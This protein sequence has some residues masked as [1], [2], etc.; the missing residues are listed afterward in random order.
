V[1]GVFSHTGF[2]DAADGASH[3]ATTY[4]AALS[5]I[6]HLKI[7]N[8]SCASEAENLVYTAI[9]KFKEKRDK[10]ETPDSVIFFLGREN[11]P[12]S[13]T[14][15]A[16]YPWKKAQVLTT[17]SAA[18][19]VTSGVLLEKALKAAQELKKENIEVTVVNH[20]FVNIPDIETLTECLKK[21]GGKLITTE[22]HQL[23]CGQGAQI[24]HA[25]TIKGVTIQKYIGLGIKGEFGQSAYTANE[26]Y[27]KHGIDETALINAVRSLL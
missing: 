6:P 21:T 16:T 18:T 8:L 7:I 1:I 23:V 12:I 20:P 3:Q 25:L 4:F 27:K 13:F 15:G 26:L 10:G 11:H 22:D 14:E 19:I 24:V 5:G 9:T 17:G 2:Q